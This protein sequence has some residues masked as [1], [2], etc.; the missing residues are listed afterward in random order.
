MRFEELTSHPWLY[1]EQQPKRAGLETI[2]YDQ[3]NFQPNGD[4][5][6]TK[7]TT[8]YVFR[9]DTYRGSGKGRIIGFK[10]S[11]CAV[12]HVIGYDFDFSAYQ[13]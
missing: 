10:E 5:V 12:Y 7:D 2:S 4:I 6:I 11:P 1:W 8:L 9:F 3:L 13:H